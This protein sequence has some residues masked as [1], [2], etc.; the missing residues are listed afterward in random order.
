[1]LFSKRE[2][3]FAL[4]EIYFHLISKRALTYGDRQQ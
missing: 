1:M 3:N 2:V 4:V